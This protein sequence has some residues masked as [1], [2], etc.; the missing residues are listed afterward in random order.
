PGLDL[1]PLLDLHLAD[2]AAFEVLDSLPAS[3]DDHRPRSDRGAV[4]RRKGSPG[5]EAAEEDGD[6]CHAEQYRLAN[7]DRLVVDGRP[8]GVGSVQLTSRQWGAAVAPNRQFHDDLTFVWLPAETTKDGRGAAVPV[9]SRAA[10]GRKSASCRP[11][12][13]RSPSAMC[14]AEGSSS[15]SSA[16][17]CTSTLLF[18]VGPD[19]S[20]CRSRASAWAAAIR[21]A[22][23]T[24]ASISSRGPNISM[25]PKRI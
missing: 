9:C 2:D 19:V 12:S 4:E 22:G 14:V 1:A 8:V 21:G 16:S 20:P 11:G 5:A 18:E 23:V 25:R 7:P 15:S 17:A 3:T 13:R 24:F 6:Q 10:A